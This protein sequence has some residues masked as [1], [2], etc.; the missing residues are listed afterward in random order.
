M[1]RLPPPA[2]PPSQAV[3]QAPTALAK[4]PPPKAQV[5][6]T[7]ATAR[8]PPLG[9]AAKGRQ[10]LA[11]TGAVRC[12][13]ASSLAPT[14]AL[15]PPRAATAAEFCF[16]IRTAAAEGGHSSAN[17]FDSDA[18]WHEAESAAGT[19]AAEGAAED[20]TCSQPPP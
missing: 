20:S 15:P 17:S 13:A 6:S 9:S 7:V 18:D 5:L 11:N 2:T 16:N 19:P 12:A 8:P 3:T 4:P 10:Q 1:T 14:S